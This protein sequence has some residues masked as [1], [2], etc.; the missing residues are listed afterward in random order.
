MAEERYFFQDFLL[1]D[2]PVDEQDYP[3]V[4]IQTYNDYNSIESI[5][6]MIISFD[7]LLRM[8]KKTEWNTL[9]STIKGKK[10]LINDDVPI[11]NSEV[12]PIKEF[13]LGVY[14]YN[15]SKHCEECKVLNHNYAKSD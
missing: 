13:Y 3:D 15:L 14:F 9:F 8:N 11:S 6:D 2:M 12:K 7:K 4:I 1:E 10:V 5:S